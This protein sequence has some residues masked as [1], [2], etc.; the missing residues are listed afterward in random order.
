[1]A[2]NCGMSYDEIKTNMN[3]K[4]N[5]PNTNKRVI[6]EMMAEFGEPNYVAMMVI[7]KILYDWDYDYERDCHDEDY[8]S[9]EFDRDTIKKMGA[10]IN[11][12][13]GMQ[14]MQQNFYT[15][16]FFMNPGMGTYL[17]DNDD[18]KIW[19]VKMRKVEFIWDGIGD[20]NM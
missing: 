3:K 12:R 17:E 18:E 16:K 7:V 11:Q 1:M 6:I 9:P 15:M 2:W 8:K 14:S 20:W 5:E 10:K 19:N 4:L 13:G